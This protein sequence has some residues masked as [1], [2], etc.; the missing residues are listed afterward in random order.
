M[1]KK[2]LFVDMDGTLAKF[3]KVDELETLYEK[4]YFLNLEPI[5][6]VI[7]AVKIIIKKHPEVEVN[8]LSS[9]LSDSQYALKE[10]NKWL[11]KYLPEIDSKHRIFPPCGIDKKDYIAG[12][13]SENDFL[14]DDYTQNL[15]LWQPPARGIKLLNGINN[16]HGTW[17]HDCI[18]FNESANDILTSVKNI[19]GLGSWLSID[20]ICINKQDYFL[21][22][23]NSYSENAANIIIDS[24]GTLILDDVYNGFDDLKYMLESGISLW[25][26]KDFV[27]AQIEQYLCN[28]DITNRD[29]TILKSNLDNLGKKMFDFYKKHPNIELSEELNYIDELFSKTLK[30]NSKENF[31]SSVKTDL[32]KNKELLKNKNPNKSNSKEKRFN[33][34]R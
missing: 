7:D 21:M 1:N 31:R 29:E 14:L 19:I 34:N 11:D 33:Y 15:N 8:I 13:V 5:D 17:K 9:V 18:S 26:A 27:S 24:K 3:K 28:E 32:Q 20:S 23:N 16:T 6:N 12:D 4:G 25:G 22:K 2:R 30:T 10:K